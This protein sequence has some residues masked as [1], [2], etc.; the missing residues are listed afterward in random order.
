MKRG[1]E[2]E[3]AKSRTRPVDGGGGS[4][5]EKK[6]K[7][8]SRPGS[9]ENEMLAPCPQPP[10]FPSYIICIILALNPYTVALLS[11]PPGTHCIYNSIT[12]DFGPAVSQDP[13]RPTAQETG[14]LARPV[15]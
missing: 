10:P 4:R 14:T 1:Y 9:V 7:K 13:G 3:F 2:M 15:I 6:K 11:P 12:L 5:K 8:G